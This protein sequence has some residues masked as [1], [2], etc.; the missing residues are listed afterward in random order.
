MSRSAPRRTRP[1]R[2]AWGAALCRV[3]EQGQPPASRLFSDPVVGR[4]LDPMIVT[5]A[6][7]PM[8][9]LYLSELG[10]GT[11][12]AQI[13]RTRYIDDVVTGLVEGGTTQV[14]ILGAGLDTRAFRLPVLA[15]ATV[16]ELDLPGTQQY[17]VERL[18]GVP[19]L[20]A[21]V[22]FIP[23]DFATEPLGDVLGAAG[24][25]RTNPVLFVWEGVTQYLP[26]AAVRS[27]LA[28]IGASVPGSALVFTYVRRGIVDGSSWEGW[29]DGQRPRLDA[30][31]PWVFGL[32]PGEVPGLLDSY[33]LSLVDDVGEAEFRSRY[34]QPLGRRVT[35]NGVERVAL[36]VVR[37]G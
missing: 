21:E 17:K 11:Y 3:I 29:S 20:A 1:S 5:M 26:E 14:V 32:E 15:G 9:E 25:D 16:L 34:A 2:T 19:A 27:T 13:M 33:G 35:L 31:E 12:G 10:S 8:R 24:L 4:L 37:A 36:A 18:R 22:R 30:S 6:G 23:T 28:C 7:G